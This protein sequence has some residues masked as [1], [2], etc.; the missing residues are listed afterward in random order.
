M[1]LLV[2]RVMLFVTVLIAG[3]AVSTTDPDA[4]MSAVR[5]TQMGEHQWMITCVDSPQYCASLANRTCPQGYDVTSNT[6]NPNDYGRMTMIIKCE[7]AEEDNA[8]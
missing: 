8:H 3:C 2:K 5:R 6:V 1:H 4:T 7:K